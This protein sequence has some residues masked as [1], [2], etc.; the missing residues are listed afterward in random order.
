MAGLYRDDGLGVS[1]ATPRQLEQIKKKICEVYRR[2][3]LSITVETNKKVVQFLDVEF[4]LHNESYKPYIKP[5]DVPSYVHQLSN[6]PPC[7]LK[8][9][10]AAI[11]RRIS[12]LS[13][14]KEIF[15]SVAPLYQ[16]ALRKS[17]YE[18][19]LKYE[20]NDAEPNSRKRCRKRNVLW[21]NPP[22]S[23]SV[24]TNVGAEFLKL[25]DK[26]FPK[27][28]PLSK[29]VNR[30][31]TKVSYRTTSNLKKII[32]S[33]NVK[34]LRKNENTA[35]KRL[36]NCHDKTKC[37][38]QGKCLVDNLVY[39]AT[40]KS[41]NSEESYVGLA[42]TTFKLRLGNHKKS[43]NHAT[44]RTDSSLSSHIWDIKDNGGEYELEWKLIGRAQPFSP[45]T[46]VCNLCTLEKYHILFT[47]ELATINKKEE[48]NNHCLHKAQM[49][50]D[51]T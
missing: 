8:N 41:D 47:P 46:G 34:V 11:N 26:H 31:N 49:L 36:C 43:F 25:I 22:Y 45:V 7:V 40:V 9:I 38:L 10:P 50:L 37:P 24:K 3:G 21:F 30:N 14:N 13:S 27:S 32:S 20:E 33:H 28:N 5:N 19:E 16:E 23:I 15:M 1:S 17:G 44:Y 29:V 4:D 51:K 42:S 48:I 18:Y 6:H 39:Q 2:H 12:A 35:E